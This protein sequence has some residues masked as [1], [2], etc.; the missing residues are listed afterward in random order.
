MRVM[1]KWEKRLVKSL[2]F[3]KSSVTLFYEPLL[4]NSGYLIIFSAFN[5]KGMSCGNR[6]YIL[7]R[8][9]I[10]AFRNSAFGFMNGNNWSVFDKQLFHLLS[11]LLIKRCVHFGKYLHHPMSNLINLTS[12]LHTPATDII[13]LIS[14]RRQFC[15]KCKIV[16][17]QAAPHIIKV[18]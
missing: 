10:T 11:S 4:Y 16:C 18:N 3:W 9:V 13:G 15:R 2:W 6:N 5:K 1:T 8:I 17:V 14:D 7:S 12:K